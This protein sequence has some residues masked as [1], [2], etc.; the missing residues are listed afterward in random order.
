MKRARPTKHAA[1]PPTK[2]AR[3]AQTD[4]PPPQAHTLPDESAA[5]PS[6]RAAAHAQH[7]DPL[8]LLLA[9]RDAT[10][11]E[12]TPY[13]EL[14]QLL[15]LLHAGALEPHHARERFADA[16]R[17]APE[18]ARLLAFDDGHLAPGSPLVHAA[19]ALHG[20]LPLSE[21][22]LTGAQYDAV[23]ARAVELGAR[24]PVTPLADTTFAPPALHP[25]PAWAG[26]SGARL[27][28]KRTIRLEVASP[29]IAS[30]AA[31]IAADVTANRVTLVAPKIAASRGLRAHWRYPAGF[32]G[33]SNL[34]AGLFSLGDE[35]VPSRRK[36][37]KFITADAAEGHVSFSA[38]DMSRLDDGTYVV[39]LIHGSEDVVLA[40][41]QTVQLRCGLPPRW[42]WAHGFSTPSEGALRR[43][44]RALPHGHSVDEQGDNDVDDERCYFE[45]PLVEVTLTTEP[46]LARLLKCALRTVDSHSYLDWGLTSDYV[47]EVSRRE[48]GASEGSRRGSGIGGGSGAGAELASRT[49]DTDAVAPRPEG[50]QMEPVRGLGGNTKG[51]EGYGEVTNGSVSRL[52]AVLANLRSTVLCHLAPFWPRAWDLT[53]ESEFVDIGSGYG[54]VVLQVALEARAR[55]ACGIECVASRHQIAVRALQEVRAQ[56]L[57]EPGLGVGGEPPALR[58]A[59]G[60]SA[61]SSGALDTDSQ[62]EAATAAAAAPTAAASPDDHGARFAADD[63]ETTDAFSAV[64]LHFGDATLGPRLDFSHIY[65]FDRVFSA[66][67]LRALAATLVASRWRVLVSFRP[68]AEWWSHGLSCAQPVCKVRMQTTG[69]ESMVAFVYA[70]VCEMPDGAVPRWGLM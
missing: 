11:Y 5:T 67:T 56:M 26:S 50:R 35:F 46:E 1:R 66:T 58:L 54:K 13:Y 9:L 36:K 60:T 31:S 41:S 29:T 68:C 69:R 6:T 17:G 52:L 18:R 21:L 57:L 55:R 44:G 53:S 65:V 59:S 38:A 23:Q 14:V 25:R 8:R 27:G 39:S 45:V 30:E 62:G 24:D 32:A 22:R 49:N 37:Y 43:G 51:S 33:S 3:T 70:N 15:H 16:M 48:S 4:L 7:V 63:D 20:S 64:H 19:L 42:G 12:P 34:W 40:T 61:E 47:S 2:A 28:K 10:E